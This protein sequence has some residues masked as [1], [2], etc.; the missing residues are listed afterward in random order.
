MRDDEVYALLSSPGWLLMP[1]GLP[2]A[3]KSTLGGLLIA[4]G[5]MDRHGILS[6]DRL[7]EWL[8]G[9]RDW[10]GD[11]DLVFRH[12]REILAAR[13]RNGLSTYFDATNIRA[14]DRNYAFTAA[15]AAGRAVL[16]IRFAEP[17]EMCRR[18]RAHQG[19]VYDDQVWDGLVKDLAEIDWSRLAAPWVDSA[20]L[21]R[22][23]AD[24][25]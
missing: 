15:Q 20:A 19:V 16:V 4:H 7:R 25:T 12:A 17:E 2:G 22:I 8:G 18:R 9:R 14:A 13:L 11:E 23:I 1:V 24:Q 21:A 3:G 10:L 6:T 5:L